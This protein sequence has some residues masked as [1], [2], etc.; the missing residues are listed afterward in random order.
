VRLRLRVEMLSLDLSLSLIPP[1]A[2]LGQS[3]VG[4]LDKAK[5]FGKNE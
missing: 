3:Q 2:S 5:V 1:T 4:L